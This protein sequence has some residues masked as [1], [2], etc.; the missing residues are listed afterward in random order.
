MLAARHSVIIADGVCN[1][2]RENVDKIIEIAY[3]EVTF[4]E[5]DVTD[6]EAVEILFR[7]DKID[8]VIHFAGHKAV[9]ESVEKPLSLLLQ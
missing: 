2:K 5:F 7:N 8:G 6:P 1:S 4:Y 9:G 3:K